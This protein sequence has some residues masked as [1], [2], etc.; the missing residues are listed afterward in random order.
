MVLPATEAVKLLETPTQT[1]E[2]VA[3][4]FVGAAGGATQAE[5]TR[6]IAVAAPTHPPVIA[7][8]VTVYVSVPGTV[9]V[10][11]IGPVEPDPA[12]EEA[13]VTPPAQAHA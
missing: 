7:V 11:E 10:T 4:W 9:G 13:P 12:V 8:G 5:T 2:R 1:V 3:I 6:L